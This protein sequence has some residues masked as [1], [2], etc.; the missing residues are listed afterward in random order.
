MADEKDL[1]QD[2]SDY[3]PSPQSK[4]GGSLKNFIYSEVSD[5]T[6]A[7]VDDVGQ[8][9]QLAEFFAR[10]Y[11]SALTSVSNS[12]VLKDM[13]NNLIQ[14][15]VDLTQLELGDP[16][17][18]R[19]ELVALTN[20]HT[21]YVKDAATDIQK[22]SYLSANALDRAEF[23]INSI[24]ARTIRSS[25]D[26]TREALESTVTLLDGTAVHYADLLERPEELIKNFKDA[27]LE[28]SRTFKAVSEGMSI[29]MIK[30]SDE[31]TRRF[32][33]S[34]QDVSQLI[35][36]EFSKSGKVTGEVMA[37]FEKTILASAELGMN[38]P[39]VT[40][41][42]MSMMNDIRHFGEMTQAEMASL[43]NTMSQMG[44]S[45]REVTSIADKFSSF[46]SAIETVNKLTAATGASLDTM[47]LFELSASGDMEEFV[48]ELKLQFEDAGVEFDSLNR[49]Q[50]NMLA[51]TFGVEP[52][53]LQRIMNDNIGAVGSIAEAVG[54]ASETMTRSEAER[55]AASMD[56]LVPEPDPEKYAEKY[57]RIRRMSLDSVQEVENVNSAIANQ[58]TLRYDVATKGYSAMGEASNAMSKAAS[59]TADSWRALSTEIRNAQVAAKAAP[60]TAAIPVKL[61]G[62]E[63]VQAAPAASPAAPVATPAITAAPILQV[64]PA[65][66][67]VAAASTTTTPTNPASPTQPQAPIR[68]EIV[69][70]PGTEKYVT[71]EHVEHGIPLGD[72][73]LIIS[74]QQTARS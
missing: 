48:E 36:V 37:E 64:A 23:G 2:P 52:E 12:D 26:M 5:G 66:A 40:K 71:F 69:A 28:D 31:L 13:S 55:R 61:I 68:V 11:M 72:R 46:D 43:S 3:G 27:A 56:K 18:A 70:A 34:A 9:A 54:N 57:A 30:T 25:F 32:G 24:T 59:A 74:T 53:I 65:P 42:V 60:I 4:A 17:R 19:E 1:D 73:H 33:L 35:Q 15:G 21:K 16:K 29:D 8:S 6:K 51:S 49:L 62:D 10:S 38:I 22:I 14:L 7:F 44:L 20:Q 63:R 67:T 41:D 45:L 39:M 58:I 50:K 47:K